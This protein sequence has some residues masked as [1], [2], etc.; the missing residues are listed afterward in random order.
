MKIS[1]KKNSWREAKEK[2]F[3]SLKIDKQ[4]T[5]KIYSRNL[6]F[7]CKIKFIYKNK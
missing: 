1:A 4:E 5:K 6:G 2:L 3:V 7:E